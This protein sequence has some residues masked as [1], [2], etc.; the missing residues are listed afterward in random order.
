MSTIWIRDNNTWK[1]YST[2]V[3]DGGV[4]K[5]ITTSTF[6]PDEIFAQAEAELNAEQS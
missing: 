6:D 2:Y 1:Q 3:R 4:W 5:P